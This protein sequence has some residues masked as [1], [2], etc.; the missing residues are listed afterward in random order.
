[1]SKLGP[2]AR[3][4]I[5]DCLTSGDDEDDVARKALLQILDVLGAPDKDQLER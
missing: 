5:P 3:A 2:A 4:A 1:V